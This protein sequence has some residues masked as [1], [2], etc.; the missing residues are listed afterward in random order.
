MRSLTLSLI[1]IC[2]GFLYMARRAGVSFAGKK[3][4]I[5]GTGGTSG[6]ASYG[7]KREGAREVVL[8]SRQGEN[9]YENLYRHRDGEILVNTTPV[10]MFPRNG[11]APLSLAE[12]P[13]LSGVL[14]VIY[15]PLRTRIILDAEERGIPCSG[16][17]A[18]LVRQAHGAAEL[19]TGHEIPEE[20]VE[21]ALE[22]VSRR[23]ENI[24]LI[25][26]AGCG[27][28][29]VGRLVS[30][31][32]GRTFVDT[33][34]L[35]EREAG[36]SI[37]QIFETQGEAAFR[38][39]EAEA[40]FQASRM[41]GAVIATG[42]GAVLDPE[43]RRALRQNGRVFFLQRPVK[44]LPREGRPLS[45]RAPDLEALYEERLP[46]Y[47][48]CCDSLIHNRGS[49]QEAANEIIQEYKTP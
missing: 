27:K 7:A 5:L 46:I 31:A 35:V 20:R 6:T 29:A 33:D 40:V 34:A 12:F 15:N 11:E 2:D 8:V 9:N 24:V 42:G 1:H 41:S 25:G 37:P 48:D 23:V 49:L 17:L 10:G 22:T 18:M 45:M 13:D 47:L 19:F 43:N 3:V 44:D 21:A 36:M 26:M 30:Q 16:G 4:I 32:L 39:Q 38:K 14:D 28:T